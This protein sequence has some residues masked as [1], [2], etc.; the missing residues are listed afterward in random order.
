MKILLAAALLVLLAATPS[1]AY[2]PAPWGTDA[3]LRELTFDALLVVDW[4]QTRR[5]AENPQKYT[6]N[7]AILGPHPS[8]GQVDTYMI[9]MFFLHFMVSYLLPEDWRATWQ[10]VSIGVEGSVVAVNISY[11]L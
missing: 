5:V 10:M 8:V 11:G 6:E 1:F 7:N 9:S 3:T 2:E 4:G